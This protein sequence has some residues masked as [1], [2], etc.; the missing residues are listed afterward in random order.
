[1]GE[2]LA[3]VRDLPVEPSRIIDVLAESPGGANA[4]K[5]IGAML[6]E[7]WT[8]G[9]EP[10]G[11]FP[12]GG[13]RKDGNL[14]LDAASRQAMPLPVLEAALAS[15]DEAAAAGWGARPLF[16]QA[17]YRRSTAPDR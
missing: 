16:A 7:A 17:L 5:I 15:Y 10:A 13:V 9:Q 6:A 1:L 8:S 3:L 4:M 14:M 11:F 12:L 2:A